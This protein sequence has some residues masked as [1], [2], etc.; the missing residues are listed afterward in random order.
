M[1]LE[2]EV[3]NWFRLHGNCVSALLKSSLAAIN[4]VTT[5]S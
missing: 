2:E 1:L 4:C 3:R 5:T